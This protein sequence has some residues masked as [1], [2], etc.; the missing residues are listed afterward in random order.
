MKRKPLQFKRLFLLTGLLI[1]TISTAFSQAITGVVV[2]AI[3]GTTII[4]AAV[5][6]KGTTNGV[7]TNLDGKFS[8]N[9]SGPVV[10]QIRYIGYTSK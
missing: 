5:I 4:G 8:L 6:E 7:A 3:D 10:L 2:D 1:F 9:V